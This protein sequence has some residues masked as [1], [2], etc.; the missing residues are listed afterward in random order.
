VI[1]TIGCVGYATEQGLGRLAKDFYDHGVVQSMMIYDH[2][3]GRRTQTEWYPPGTPRVSG[4]DWATNPRHRD[5][6]ARFVES[7]DVVLF[8]EGDEGPL[9]SYRDKKGK[10][11][12]Q[13][14]LTLPIVE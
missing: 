10:Y 12:D 9:V 13:A 5:T 11:Q 2:P 7:V 14:G 1:P 3:D 6:V 4:R 8:F